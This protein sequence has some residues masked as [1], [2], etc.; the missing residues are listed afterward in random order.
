MKDTLEYKILKYLKENDNGDF[1]DVNSFI[2][3]RKLLEN[4]L[5]SLSKESDKYISVKFPFFIVGGGLPDIVDD[6]LRAKIEFKGIQLIDEIEKESKSINNTGIY[7][8][9]NN[10]KGTQSFGK[11][12]LKGNTKHKNRSIKKI[13]NWASIKSFCVKFWWTFLIP[14]LVIILGILIERGIIDIGI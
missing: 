10:G 13:S 4:K 8:E 2:E 5:R 9:A 7:I 14:L 6:Q 12:N 3:D 1:L 11:I